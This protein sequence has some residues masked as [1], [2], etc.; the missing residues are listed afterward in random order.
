MGFGGRSCEASA[1]LSLPGFIRIGDWLGFT[2]LSLQFGGLL[3]DPLELRNGCQAFLL[4]AK[5]PIGEAHHIMILRRSGI[6]GDGL[7]QG[8]SHVG[9]VFHGPVGFRHLV[10]CQIGLGIQFEGILAR[11]PGPPGNLRSSCNNC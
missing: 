6:N 4:P 9:P 10:V 11:T 3:L 1:L 5:F 7:F 2:P 8:L